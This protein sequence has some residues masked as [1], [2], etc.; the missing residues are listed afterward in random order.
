MKDLCHRDKLHKIQFEKT[1]ILTR[2]DSAEYL[3]T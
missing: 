3:N 2:G 1:I